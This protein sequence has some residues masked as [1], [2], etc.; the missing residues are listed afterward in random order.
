MVEEAW[1]DEGDVILPKEAHDNFLRLIEFEKDI[2]DDLKSIKNSSSY[3]HMH[4]AICDLI[5]ELEERKSNIKG[6][7]NE[8]R[9]RL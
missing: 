8:C 9:R 3:S 5:N 4:R 1:L 7:S 6:E 2:I